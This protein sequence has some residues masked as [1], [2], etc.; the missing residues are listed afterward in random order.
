MCAGDA[1]GNSGEDIQLTTTITH[2]DGPSEIYKMTGK[3]AQEQIS[4]C[5][6]IRLPSTI[7]CSNHPLPHV[8]NQTGFSLYVPLALK[9]HQQPT[10]HVIYQSPSFCPLPAPN[11]QL[12][13][14]FRILLI[15]IVFLKAEY[16][17]HSCQ[18][19]SFHGGIS[20]LH[21]ILC[22]NYVVSV[23]QHF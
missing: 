23:A 18:S 15:P 17:Q 12:C 3:A 19:F 14:L 22:V 1:G 4:H 16:Y 20:F 5:E 11:T 9:R 6:T 10:L 2:V 8:C 13:D 21:F 7:Y